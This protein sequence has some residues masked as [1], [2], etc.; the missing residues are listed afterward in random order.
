[1]CVYCVH[2]CVYID[3]TQYTHHKHLHTC[4]VITLNSCHNDTYMYTCLCSHK[5]KELPQLLGLQ[6]RRMEAGGRGGR[7]EEREI[8]RYN[9]D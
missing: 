2:A 5:Y 6:R 9:R 8:E 1:M 7:G 4:T 3:H